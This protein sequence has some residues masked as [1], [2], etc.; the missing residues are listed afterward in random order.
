MC[1]SY[2]DDLATGIITATD[3]APGGAEVTGYVCVR[4]VGSRAVDVAAS[5]IDLVD[6]DTG[7]TGDE[8]SLDTTCGGDQA[9]ELSTYLAV[10]IEYGVGGPVTNYCPAPLP[11][12]M[13]GG[14]VDTLTTTTSGHF[15]LDPD[16]ELFA[17]LGFTV[18]DVALGDALTTSQ[19]DTA[20]WRFAFDASAA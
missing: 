9:G 17:C 20:T 1:G 8:A 5:V 19:S 4:N 7:C 2:A 12:G 16:P 13:G 18:R 11:G 14:S 15:T 3:M 10:S 6:S